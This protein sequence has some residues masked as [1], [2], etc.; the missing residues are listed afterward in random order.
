MVGLLAVALLEA[1]RCTQVVARIEALESLA[2]NPYIQRSDEL[3]VELLRSTA[4]PLWFHEALVM[5]P[6]R[7]RGRR[8]DRGFGAG[9]IRARLASRCGVDCIH[10]GSGLHRASAA[11]CA[12]AALHPPRGF[13]RAPRRLDAGEFPFRGRWSWSFSKR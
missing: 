4:V 5:L 2:E 6:T 8:R 1:A 7:R 10:M 11:E 13:F 12:A 9:R 3:V